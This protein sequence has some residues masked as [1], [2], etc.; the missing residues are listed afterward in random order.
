MNGKK[1]FI[2]VLALVV[3]GVLIFAA[4]LVAAR[5]GIINVGEANS[6]KEVKT[7]IVPGNSKF[8]TNLKGAR[9]I[10]IFSYYIETLKDK[11]L[12]QV[13]EEWDPEARSRVL[14][15]IRDKTAEDVT[16]TQGKISLEREILDCYRPLYGKEGIINIYIDDLIT[17]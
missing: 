16:G 15:I 8:Q 12:L 2:F 9:S 5:G 6:N 1:L 17:Q 7:V 10:I 4:A 11:K 3:T 13:L 14:N